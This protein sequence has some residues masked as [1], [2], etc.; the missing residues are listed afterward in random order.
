MWP[1]ILAPAIR[2]TCFSAKMS[3]KSV[4]ETPESSTVKVCMEVLC[5][6]FTINLQGSRITYFLY[7]VKSTDAV[8]FDGNFWRSEST[9]GYVCD[10]LEYLERCLWNA[11]PINSQSQRGV[12]FTVAVSSG[13]FPPT[14]YC[15]QITFFL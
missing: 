15:L 8:N 4:I 2:R 9:D 12:F 13:L 10:I 6:R 1:K 11:V 14:R 7:A 5:R 3:L